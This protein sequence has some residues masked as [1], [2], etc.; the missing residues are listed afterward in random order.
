MEGR[1]HDDC[2]N[3]HD[4]NNQTVRV[5]FLR[6]DDGEIEMGDSRNW[7]LNKTPSKEGSRDADKDESERRETQAFGDRA[8][9][10]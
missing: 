3:K 5:G 7:S 1:I 4:T 2:T 10:T 6:C 8:Q 9:A